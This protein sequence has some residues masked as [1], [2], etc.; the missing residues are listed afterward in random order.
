[1]NQFKHF[2][3]SARTRDRPIAKQD[4]AGAVG[5]CTSL[6]CFCHWFIGSCCVK[7]RSAG[8]WRRVVLW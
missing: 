1:M 4:N 3:G 8:L 6:K 5:S 7:S 2:V